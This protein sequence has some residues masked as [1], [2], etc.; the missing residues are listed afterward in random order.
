MQALLLTFF[1][2]KFMSTAIERA[3][4]KTFIA[5]YRFLEAYYGALEKIVGL[6][7]G[8]DRNQS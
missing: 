5:Y 2:G 1:G 4:S 8:K 6:I 7:L 3:A